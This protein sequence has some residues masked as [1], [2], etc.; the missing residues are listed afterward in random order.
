MQ[1]TLPILLGFALADSINITSLGVLANHLNG[2]SKDKRIQAGYQ[3][4]ASFLCSYLTIGIFATIV[5]SFIFAQTSLIFTLIGL[6][7]IWLGFV[8]LWNILKPHSSI[9][10]R[11]QSDSSKISYY[12]T[13]FGSLPGS[14]L[15]LGINTAFREVYHSGGFYLGFLSLL[16]INNTGSDRHSFI[17]FYNLI[18]ALPLLL[19]THMRSAD[20]SLGDLKLWETGS[21]RNMLL[22]TATLEMVLGVWILFWWFV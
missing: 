21:R 4:T 5:I 10:S 15:T 8:K 12:L 1:L 3:Y 20:L 22:G 16:V 11:S 14:S 19:L 7:I 6:L 18:V 2:L 13:Q 17:L 9:V